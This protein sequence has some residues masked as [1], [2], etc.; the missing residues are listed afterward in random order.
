V[1]PLAATSKVRCLAVLI[2][3]C[4]VATWGCGRQG[5]DVH[6]GAEAGAETGTEAGAPDG[7]GVWVVE[8]GS[9]GGFT[10]GGSGYIVRSDGTVV[11]WSRV[12]PDD[13]VQMEDPRQASPE[14]LAALRRAMVDPELETLQMAKSGNMTSFLVRRL[15]GKER[16]WSWP[17]RVRDPDVPASLA[18]F[19][20][21]ALQA[22]RTAQ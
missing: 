14:A 7:L 16:R 4:L 12:T 11:A 21:A 2:G 9:Q 22:A 20:E 3:L 5:N 10:G 8:V 18:R 15:D 6:A 19:Y 17:E 13:P 1:N